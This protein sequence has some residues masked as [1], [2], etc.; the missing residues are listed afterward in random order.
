[1][2][3]TAAGAVNA[4]LVVRRKESSTELAAICCRNGNARTSVMARKKE[5]VLAEG[6]LQRKQ[7]QRAAAQVTQGQRMQVRQLRSRIENASRHLLM[8]TR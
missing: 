8:L 5:V 4:S 7:L 2:T 6:G 1:M 3:V